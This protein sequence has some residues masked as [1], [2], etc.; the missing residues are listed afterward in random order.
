MLSDGLAA[1]VRS[2]YPQRPKEGSLLRQPLPNSNAAD[3]RFDVKS[4]HAK[5]HVQHEKRS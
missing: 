2:P 4:R 1:G 5:N 3:V